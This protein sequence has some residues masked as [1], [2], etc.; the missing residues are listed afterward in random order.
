MNQSHYALT[1]VTAPVGDPLTLEEVKAHLRVDSTADDEL[2]GALILA[3]RLKLESDT[4]RALLTRTYDLSLDGWPASG[5]L[6]LPYSPVQS[7]TSIT[8]YDTAN[9][10][11]V[12]AASNYQVDAASVPARIVPAYGAVWP[13][14]T[15]RSLN[16]VVIRYV[17]GYGALAT[18][19]E[20]DRQA[21]K[22]L[23]AHW[24]ENREAVGA[25]GTITV[26]SRAVELAYESLIW[27]DR[28][29]AF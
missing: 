2:I 5:V 1:V 19:P 26:V 16:G 6:L 4:G 22:L 8:Y 20:T 17:A 25:S 23:V 3:A 13:A 28:V 9:V 21:M 29:K 11:T 18:I 14:V 7:V 24:Y 27:M 15:L 10:A 12:W